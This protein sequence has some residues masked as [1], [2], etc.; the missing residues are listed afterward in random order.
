MSETIG[1]HLLGRKYVPDDRDWKMT[2]ALALDYPT[3]D[4][5]NKTVRQVLDDGTYFSSWPGILLFWRWIKTVDATPT[6]TPPP[7]PARVWDDPI[8]LDQGQTGHCVGFGW[9]GWGDCAPVQD[10]FMNADAHAIYYEAK[11]IDGQPRQEN[12]SSVRS[13]AKAMVNRKRLGAY[14]FA[15]NVDEVKQWV[16]TH[17]PVVCGTD[18][19]QDMFNPDPDGT[20]HP[21]GRV[22]GGHCYLMLG[23]DQ[24]GD[25]FTFENSWG[26]TWGLQGRFRM[27]SA[28]F[29]TLLAQQGEACAGL[30][31]PLP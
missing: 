6:P 27:H 16:L 11:V 12:G 5:L 31:L 9:A 29:A 7:P 24:G 28:D 26:P 14:V 3:A 18:W 10:R 13:G 23:Y 2:V 25:A 15:T 17:G 30:E 20:V 19:T 1:P 8:Q 21:T 4:L 22:A